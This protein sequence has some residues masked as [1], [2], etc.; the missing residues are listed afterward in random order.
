MVSL[1]N[2]SSGALVTNSDFGTVLIAGN[3]GGGSSSNWVDFVDETVAGGAVAEL[4]SGTI[5]LTTDRLYYFEAHIINNDGGGPQVFQIG[6]NGNTTS[7]DYRKGLAYS[8]GGRSD[9]SAWLITQAATSAQSFV[10]G[11]IS[12][13]SSGLATVTLIANSQNTSDRLRAQ[14][15]HLTGA[16]S[17]TELFIRDDVGGSNLAN[18]SRLIIKAV[19]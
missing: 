9:S 5:S 16:S 13:T 12:E 18:N 6:I 3:N 15:A 2:P 11:F 17:I 7:G 19:E 10:S 4:S 14:A 8:G 1:V